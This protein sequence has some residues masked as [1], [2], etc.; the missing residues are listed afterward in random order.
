MRPESEG[1]IYDMSIGY[2][3]AGIKSAKVRRFMDGMLD[4]TESVERLRHALPLRLGPLRE[5]HYPTRLS[6]SVTLSTFHGCPADEIERIC[7]FLLNEVG[8]HTVVK[9]NPP[10]L[11][12]EPLEYLLHDVMGYEQIRVNESAYTSGLQF[13]E[14]VEMTR[15]LTA[16]ARRQGLSFGAKFSNT[17]EV[18]N[19]RAF[20]PSSEKIMYLSGPPL[21]VI[22]LTLAG[23]YRRAVGGEVPISFS[24]G[25]DRRNFFKLVQCG[26][27]PITTCT[28]LLKFGGYGRLPHYLLD[29][30]KE[31]QR[32]GATNIT[33]YIL[34]CRS[35]RQ[36][37]HNP[38]AA[39]LYNLTEVIAETQ[40]DERYYQAQ[41]A[42]VPRRIESHLTL[43]DCITCYKCIP[44]CP[45]D[46]NFV[47]DTPPTKI[48]YR[49]IDVEPDGTW[50]ACGDEKLFELKRHPQIA[51]FADYCNHC[52]N[53]DTFC[54]EYDGPY[55]MKPSFF[56][57][58]TAFEDGAP[59]DGFCV[60]SPDE[61][62]ARIGSRRIRI[63]RQEDRFVVQS[64]QLSVRMDGNQFEVLSAPARTTRVDV[65]QLHAL[66]TLFKG[67][68]DPSRVHAVN[69]RFLVS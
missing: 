41:N 19:H 50:R 49:D 55:L 57:S 33:D 25:V 16:L 37:T 45:N 18:H 2:D 40:A 30:R 68:L 9:M 4:A 13:G 28:D 14:A 59:H 63:S 1:T 3:L 64:E 29:L 21:H 27:V 7:E 61:M 47:Y 46:A 60:V 12:Q 44:V 65:G 26:F 62:W 8:V 17:L 23:E 67:I 39:G 51:N 15:H 11:G 20:F 10:M 43:F 24:A 56:G 42:S 66:V 22:T 31:M 54:P 38:A 69:T 48:T 52:G 5:L 35:A 58:P 6:R 34:D 36:T 53:C 32:V